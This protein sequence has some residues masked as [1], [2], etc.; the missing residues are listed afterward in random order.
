MPYSSPRT[1][2]LDPS[3]PLSKATLRTNRCGR[4][5]AVRRRA[6]S[7]STAV[8]SGHQER[9]Q[10]LSTRST[11][12]ERSPFVDRQTIESDS[13]CPG[14]PSSGRSEMGIRPSICDVLGFL[15]LWENRLRRPVQRYFER[16]P[17]LPPPSYNHRHVVSWLIVTPCNSF[18]A[19]FDAVLPAIFPGDQPA[20][21]LPSTQAARLGSRSSLR[22]RT[23]LA[24]RT[25]DRPCASAARYRPYRPRFLL[26]SRDR[27]EWS[28]PISRAIRRRLHLPS[29]RNSRNCLSGS[30]SSLCCM[31]SGIMFLGPNPATGGATSIE[32]RE[33]RA[34]LTPRLQAATFTSPSKSSARR[35]AGG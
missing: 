3:L 28:L 10:T 9:R 8:R 1:P 18:G 17:N 23:R 12:T 22:P 26:T 19:S 25:T 33:S 6:C 35:Q 29:R 34:E 24:S 30:E 4:V 7:V 15:P 21:S 2:C 5:S 13:R 11:W 32:C 27:A 16:P 14:R 31:S 20:R